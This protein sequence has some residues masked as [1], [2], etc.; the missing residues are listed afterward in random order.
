LVESLTN[1][2]EREARKRIEKI[3]AMG[4]MLSSIEQRYP[5]GEIENSAFEAQKAIESGAAAVVGVNKFVEEEQVAP[6]VLTI[7]TRVEAD[8]VKRIVKYR[9]GRDEARVQAALHGLREVAQSSNQGLMA[10]M[11][12]CVRGGCTLGEISDSL[13]AVFGEYHGG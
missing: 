10:N 7:D 1:E 11:V 12:E 6:P 2:L 5:Q 13:R 3:D 4:G 9:K 8:Q